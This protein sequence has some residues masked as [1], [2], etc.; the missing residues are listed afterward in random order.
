VLFDPRHL[1]A[2]FPARPERISSTALLRTGD[3]FNA[4]AA[5]RISALPKQRRADQSILL[6]SPQISRT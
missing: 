2:P 1:G 6:Q 5:T 4:G 3:I